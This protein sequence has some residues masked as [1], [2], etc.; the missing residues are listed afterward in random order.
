[1][2]LIPAALDRLAAQWGYRPA[3]DEVIVDGDDRAVFWTCSPDRQRVVVK[4]D[5]GDRRYPRERAGL[6]VAAGAAVRVPSVVLAESGPPSVL[7]LTEIT[8]STLAGGPD[9][10][11]RVAGAT[12][13]RLHDSAMPDGL[14]RFDHRGDSW[15]DFVLWWAA[16]E[17]ERIDH[18]QLVDGTTARQC[19]EAMHDAFARMPEPARTF[20]HGDAQPDHVFIDGVASGDLKAGVIDFGDAGSGDPA[21]D[22]MVL[23]LDHPERLDAVLSGYRAD[24]RLREGLGAVGK[25]YRLL[26]HVGAANW[27]L[28]HGYD[29][30]ESV[31]SALNLMAEVDQKR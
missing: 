28:A 5:S 31:Q 12:F 27:L 15:R 20:I 16:T 21:W 14:A 11:W 10:W 29:P 2:T 25:A 1:M 26:R 7:V 23:T 13:R 8:G 9:A 24:R 30:A 22:L 6:A 19:L 3:V 4:V 17:A 18:N